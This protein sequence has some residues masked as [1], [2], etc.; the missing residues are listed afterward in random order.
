MICLFFFLLSNVRPKLQ[1]FTAHLE[2]KLRRLQERQ[3]KHKEEEEALE[4]SINEGRDCI[5]LLEAQVNK[6]VNNYR[7]MKDDMST[8]LRQKGTKTKKTHTQ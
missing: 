5:L 7:M 2:S 3:M 1:A 4:E 8:A 6:M